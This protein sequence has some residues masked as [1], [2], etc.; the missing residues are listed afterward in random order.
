[1]GVGFPIERL[2]PFKRATVGHRSALA[3]AMP[4]WMRTF[5][6]SSGQ[7]D[8]GKLGRDSSFH[9]DE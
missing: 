4:W 9:N 7:I 8:I 5:R 1:M 6:S 2:V 3:R